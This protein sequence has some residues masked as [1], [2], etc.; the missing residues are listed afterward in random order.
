MIITLT[1]EEIIDAIQEYAVMH[2]NMK[3]PIAGKVRFMES[4]SGTIEM[5]A[6][7]HEASS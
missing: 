7:I 6:E 4:E 3:P 1:Q 2:C 5:C